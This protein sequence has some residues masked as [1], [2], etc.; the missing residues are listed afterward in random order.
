[1]ISDFV[2]MSPMVFWVNVDVRELKVGMYVIMQSSWDEHPFLKNEFTITSVKQIE[3]MVKYG[4]RHVLVDAGKGL[5]PVVRP[6][7]GRPDDVEKS[8]EASAS[9]NSPVVPVQLCEV[10][11]D[12]SIS[13]PDKA[14]LV[15]ENS[16]LMMHN[17]FH[18]PT[19]DNIRESK[20]GISEVVEWILR[21]NDAADCL[22]QITDHDFYTYTHSVN[23]GIWAVSLAKELFR[24][25]EAHDL[26]ELG[27]G[28]FLHD[29]GK[30]RID[31]EII[32]KPGRLSDE[33]MIEMRRHP[34]LGFQVLDEARQLTEECKTVVLQHH[35]RADGAGYPKGLQGSQIHIYAKI[36]SIADVFD[37]L[38]SNRP[39]RKGSTPFEALKIMKNEMSNHFDQGFFEKFVLMFV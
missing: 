19:A 36:C 34:V 8:E 12:S 13:S 21:D 4:I 38:T 7:V 2:E 10:I 20:K 23:V 1:M 28:F 9:D 5:A 37:A 25:S 14:R 3:K 27:A 17:L 16:L 15:R 31:N 24:H 35:E 22:I 32:N 30:V 33:E 29:I 26:H 18:Q 11:H 6:A 39:Y